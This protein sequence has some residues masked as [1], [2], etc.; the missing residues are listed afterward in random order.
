M[1]AKYICIS[2]FCSKDPHNQWTEI[3]NNHR[4]LRKLRDIVYNRQPGIF[5][6]KRNGTQSNSVMIMQKVR[7]RQTKENKVFSISKEDL[8]DFSISFVFTLMQFLYKVRPIN[9]KFENCR[10]PNIMDIFGHWHRIYFIICF[11]TSNYHISVKI[12]YFLFSDNMAAEEWIKLFYKD[13]F[14]SSIMLVVLKGMKNSL[15]QWFDSMHHH[16]MRFGRTFIFTWHFCVLFS[17]RCHYHP[18]YYDQL[19]PRDLSL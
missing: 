14:S 10:C 12:P 19:V 18:M 5:F 1:S 8:T 17:K 16:W 15:R 4:R 7:Q 9:F 11:Q 13:F 6:Y 2:P 3:F